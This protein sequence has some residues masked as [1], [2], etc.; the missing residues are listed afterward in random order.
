VSP[1]VERVLER[2]H[3]EYLAPGTIIWA[4]YGVATTEEASR[5]A[6]SQM[7]DATAYPWRVV[8]VTTTEVVEDW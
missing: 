7:R 8:T 4:M 5:A 6:L 2:H 1:T 3:I